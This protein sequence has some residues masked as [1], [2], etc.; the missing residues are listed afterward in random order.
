MEEWKD[1]AGYEGR[2][3]VSSAG[4]VLSLAS[5]RTLSPNP[6]RKGYF[7]VNLYKGSRDS[8]KRIPIHVLVA[9]T[10]IGPRPEGMDICHNDGDKTNNY[11][12]NLRYGTRSENIVDSVNHGTHFLGSKRECKYGHDL[13]KQGHDR[14]DGCRAC[15]RGKATV[16]YHKHLRRFEKEISDIHYQNLIGDNKRLLISDIEGHDI[17]RRAVACDRKPIG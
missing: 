16:R 13:D 15:A 2:Y 8:R 14:A 5:G 4:K 7:G 17:L 6:D 10:F 12:E 3:R 11:V 9:T 1:I